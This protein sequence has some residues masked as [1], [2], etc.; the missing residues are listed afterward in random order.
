MQTTLELGALASAM[1][2]AVNANAANEK[3]EVPTPRAQELGNRVQI[4]AEIQAKVNQLKL[5]LKADPTLAIEFTQNP[6]KVMSAR[7][8]S[9]D[10]QMEI[11]GEEKYVEGIEFACNGTC[12][13]SGCC[14]TSARM[15]ETPSS[16]V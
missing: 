5:D 1:V 12:A 10:A 4:F 15:I 6:I 16:I 8:I 11:L 2:A 14:A 13:C 9:L 7:N 3:A